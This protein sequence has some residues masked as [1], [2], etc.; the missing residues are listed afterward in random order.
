RELVARAAA[1]NLHPPASF[2]S[3]TSKIETELSFLIR[4]TLGREHTAQTEQFAATAA[5]TR[6]GRYDLHIV[7][8]RSQSVGVPYS[9][10]SI[11]RGWTVPSLYGN[12]LSLGAYFSSAKGTGDTLVAVHPFA[13]D[14]DRYYRF[15][16]GD[17]VTVLHVG[18]R[19]IPIARIH[20][21]PS[22]SGPTRLG[23]FDG[24]IDI[25]A[26]RGQIVRMRGQFVTLGGQPSSVTKRILRAASGV[27]G[28][29]YA[30]F[31]NAEVDDTY[32]LP[33]FQRTEFQAAFALF[34]QQRPIFRV[35]SNIRDIAVT[36]RAVPI[37]GASSTSDSMPVPRILVSW[38]TSDSLSHFD[39]WQR[40]LGA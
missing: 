24:E 28:V 31:V 1:E 18:T 6:E 25:D 26:E 37:Q 39:A 8:Y 38:A 30:E 4:D 23:A 40:G 29:A 17:T 12:R 19:S 36:N 14:R 11:V 9:A 33:A 3:Y 35:I 13:A 21:H 7:G 15:T 10:V 5:W 2:R 16:G 22:F 20:A 27:V 32:W 34:G